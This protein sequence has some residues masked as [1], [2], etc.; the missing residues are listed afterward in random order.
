MMRLGLFERGGLCHARVLHDDG[1]DVGITIVPKLPQ[2]VRFK[3][4]PVVISVEP[5]SGGWLVHLFTA[6][7][8]S[9]VHMSATIREHAGEAHFETCVPAE[10]EVA[11]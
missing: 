3:G 6:H 1:D 11:V 2:H 10:A 9:I 7:N 8:G 4:S 5:D